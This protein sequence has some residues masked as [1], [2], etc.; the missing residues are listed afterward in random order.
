MC[1]GNLERL[2]AEELVT[3]TMP[4]VARIKAYSKDREKAQVFS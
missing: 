3:A 4:E 1:L 2:E